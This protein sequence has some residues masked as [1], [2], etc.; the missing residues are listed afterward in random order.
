MFTA[1]IVY[2]GTGVSAVVIIIG[3]T[4][5]LTQMRVSPL[6]VSGTNGPKTCN[7]MIPFYYL[8]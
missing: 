8:I 6:S 2:I 4:F 3:S 1:T 7:G 5:I